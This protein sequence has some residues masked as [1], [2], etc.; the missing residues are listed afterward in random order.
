M[1]N[2]ILSKELASGQ[3]DLNSGRFLEARQ[4]ALSLLEKSPGLI[5]AFWIYVSSGKIESDDPVFQRLQDL[6]ARNGLPP[7]QASQIQFMLG[8]CWD[9]CGE[10]DKAF[11][12]FC[13]ANR[14]KSA[15]YD[16]NGTRALAEALMSAEEGLPDTL[17]NIPFG[18]RMVFVLGMPRSGT[19]LMAQMLGAHPGVTNLGECTALAPALALERRG[20]NPHLAFLAEATRQRLASART[21]YLNAIGATDHPGQVLVDKMP[22]NWWFAPMI[23]RLFPDAL[24]LHM[25]RPRLATAW[26]CFRNDFSVGHGYATDFTQILAQ[27]DLH[28]RLANQGRRRAAPG[29][30]HEISLDDLTARPR[31]VLGP[32]LAT[33][34]LEW[35]DACLAPEAGGDMPTL[36]KWQIRQG[37]SPGLAKGWMRYLPFIE[38]TWGVSE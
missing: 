23:P 26:S 8:K 34:D 5:G 29:Q 13:A 16:Q 12:A 6:G 27:Y 15:P 21:N 9:D 20:Q 37:I 7:E 36:S 3:S 33:L 4:R 14:L 10:T 22:E 18:P 32:L 2:E 30:W 35:D 28:L 11:T 19:S 25:R 24:I 17:G 38:K 1:E 31:E